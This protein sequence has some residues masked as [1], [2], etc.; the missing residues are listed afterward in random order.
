MA[1]S[2]SF[3]TPQTANETVPNVDP[4]PLGDFSIDEHRPIKVVVIGAGFSGIIAGIR[5]PQKIPNLDL[6]IYE[7][8]A[9]VGGTWFSNRYPGLACDIPSHC[10]Q[11]TF[12]V[13][14]DWSSYYAPGAEIRKY[15]EDVAEKYKVLKYVKLSHEVTHATYN[16]T[17]GKWHILVRRA[18]PETGA[19]EQI[20]DVADVVVTAFGALSRWQMPDIPGIDKYKGVLHHSAGFDPADKTWQEVVESWKDKKVGVIGVGSSAL[21]LVP[22]LQPRVARL[23]NY[24]RGKTWLSVP[25][26]SNTFAALLGREPKTAEEFKFTPEEIE[27]LRTDDKFYDHFR[28]TVEHDINSLHSSTLRGTEMQ[29]TAQKV[30][31]QNMEEKLAKKPWIAERLIPDFPVA[32]RRLTPG[33]GYLEAL[34]EDNVEFNSTPIKRFTETGIE[35]I[36]GKHEDFDVVFCATGYDTTFQLPLKIVGRNGVELNERWKPHPVSY[37]SVAV[38]GFPNFFMSFGPNSGVGSGSLLALMEFEIMYAV[39]ATAKLQRE[40]LKSIEVK[41]E[42]LRD[43]DQYIDSYFP[44]S[45]YSENCRSW[46]KMNKSDG[47]IVGLWPGSTLHALKALRHPRWEDYNYEQADPIPNRMYWLGDGQT[48]NEKTMTGDRTY[49]RDP[50]GAWR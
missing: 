8:S 37:L 9:G 24:V 34:C 40:R 49:R 50:S 29:L 7:K 17:T 20:E 16:E 11:L 3:R 2:T 21:Q 5:F 39:Q 15:I 36:D 22:A 6:T 19:L 46:Y 48:W 30:F 12:E 45:V 23:V 27:R 14:R 13:K 41:P 28:W 18:N 31:R 33:P 25:F 43:F 38:D 32:C 35:T 42:A 26:G 1:G 47:R 10:Y 4:Y 44:K